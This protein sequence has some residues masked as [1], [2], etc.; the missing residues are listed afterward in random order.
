MTTRLDSAKI[1]SGGE[2]GTEAPKSLAAKGEAAA[3]RHCDACGAVLP[4]ALDAQVV[5][6]RWGDV[7]FCADCRR[8]LPAAEIA[9]RTR[10]VPL[11]GVPAH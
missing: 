10:E 1:V 9:Q 5:P 4:I 3:V 8:Q 11:H 2:T 6:S 7:W